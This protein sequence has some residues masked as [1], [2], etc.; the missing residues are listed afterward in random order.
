MRGFGLS[1]PGT[2]LMSRGERLN[3][4]VVGIV[5]CETRFAL[6][7]V[8]IQC[9]PVPSALDDFR[10]QSDRKTI[11]IHHHSRTRVHNV[12]LLPSSPGWGTLDQGAP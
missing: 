4:R 9:Q 2:S 7:H 11:S 10:S 3:P 6:E 5:L 12:F 8:Y 1:P